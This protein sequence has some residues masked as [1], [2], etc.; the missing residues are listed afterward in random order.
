MLQ[1]LYQTSLV[2]GE[3]FQMQNMAPCV[4][5]AHTVLLEQRRSLLVELRS[6]GYKI[7]IADNYAQL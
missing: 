6:F 5:Q 4:Q 7:K 2:S 1:N 3:R